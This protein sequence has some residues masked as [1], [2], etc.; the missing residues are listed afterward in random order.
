MYG[1]VVTTMCGQLLY[2]RSISNSCEDNFPLYYMSF[3]CYIKRRFGL[4]RDWIEL[5]N[6]HQ[7][8]NIMPNIRNYCFDACFR[9]CVNRN[10]IKHI[11]QSI[12]LF[13]YA[14]KKNFSCESS[15]DNGQQFSIHLTQHIHALP[16]SYYILSDIKRI[17]GRLVMNRRTIRK[18]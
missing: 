9:W 15:L 12:K 7:Q 14:W 8:L 17:Y 3:Y 5:W 4:S 6:I 1:C 18:W 13:I 2:Y 16:L 10:N 11:Y